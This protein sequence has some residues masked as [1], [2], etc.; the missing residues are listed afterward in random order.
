MEELINLV[1]TYRRHEIPESIP[2]EYISC[3][4]MLNVDIIKRYGEPIV[5]VVRRSSGYC[6]LSNNWIKPLAN[7]IGNRHCLEVMSGNGSLTY[8][9]RAAGAKII[10]TD[11][12]SWLIANP[13][14]SSPWVNDIEDLDAVEAVARYGSSVD[15]IIMSWP[16]YDQ[17]TASLVLEKMRE[18]NSNC[19]LIYIGESQYGCT[20]D[21]RF[22]EIAKFEPNEVI[23]SLPYINVR[24]LHDN[25]YL[26]K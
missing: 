22:F 8:A 25:I 6:L 21:D 14:E 13:D 15:F 11:N 9:L 18:V 23:D 5:D 20:A 12:R 24:H 1:E 16:P 19:K 3:E 2:Y 26:I 7:F 4:D 17:P 10:P